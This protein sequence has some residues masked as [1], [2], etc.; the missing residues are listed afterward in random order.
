MRQ[1]VKVSAEV[2]VELYT[3]ILRLT[4]KLKISRGKFIYDIVKERVED[5]YAQEFE[6]KNI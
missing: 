6:D 4:K 3:K 5:M 2:E 1:T